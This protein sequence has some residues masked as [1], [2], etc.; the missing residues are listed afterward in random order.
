MDIDIFREYCLSKPFVTEECPFGPDTLVYKVLGKIF[1]LTG[2]DEVELSLNLKCDPE[3]AIELRERYAAIIQGYHMNKTHWNTVH[4]GAL[5]ND[6]LLKELIDHSYLEVVKKMPKK[7]QAT[8]NNPD[9][10]DENQ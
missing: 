3:Y 4:T 6:K 10:N 8:I 9:V 5:N 1:A 2:L 7:L